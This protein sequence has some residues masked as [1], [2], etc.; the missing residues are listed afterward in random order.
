[1][2]RY[3]G[4]GGDHADVQRFVQY[5]LDIV[6]AAETPV[7]GA[8]MLDAG[9]GYGLFLLVCGLY[10]AGSLDGVDMDATPVQFA[11]AYTSRL[12]DHLAARMHV[13]L[14]DVMQLP[15][16]DASFD[17]VTS[18]EAVS[19]YLDVDGALH[20]LARVVRP[21]GTFVLSDGNNARNKAYARTIR[22]LWAA[23]EDGP[24]Y[25]TIGGHEVG[26]PYRE[27]REEI[28]REHA[29]SLP[30]A[31]VARLAAATTGFV[32]EQVMEA[33]DAFVRSGTAPT[34]GRSQSEVPVDPD[35]ATHERLFD[36]Y[37]LAERIRRVGFERVRVR[38]YWGGA[39]GSRSVRFA[40]LVLGA[41]SHATIATAKGF[42]IS[43]VRR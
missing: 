19:H 12:D 18:I 21:G 31:N 11:N 24:G 4:F 30:D 9:C 15:Y 7:H 26:K 32:R 17:L 37:E 40:N 27:R 36:P 43:A 35:G 5:V 34:P 8:R 20:E 14:G 16:E 42:R 3:L 28:I 6:G 23:A 33:V 29:P 13:Q 39:G 1:M 22:E 25:R 38:G 2:G 41:A 10:G